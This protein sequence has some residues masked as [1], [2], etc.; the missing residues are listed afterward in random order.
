MS[1]YDNLTL[2][3]EKG[4][5][6]VTINRP[7]ALNILNRKTVH[8]LDLLSDEL[9]KD[10]SIKVVIIVGSGDKA[11]CAGG[12][13][14]EQRS[15]NV[16]EARSWAKM[17]QS[18]LNKIENLRQPVIATVNG[19]ALGGG[20]E[21]AMACDIRIA[22]D[23]AKFALPEV[24]LGIIPGFGGT[25]RLGRLIGRGRAKEL[26]F[27]GEMIDAMEAYR[28][29]LVNKVVAPEEL[30]NAAKVMAQ[31]IMSQAPF[32]LKVCKAA[33]MEGLDVDFETGQAYEAEVFALCFAT[34]DQKEGITAFLENFW[35]N[36]KPIL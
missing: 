17:G 25:Q 16:L 31:K 7:L 11:F 12:D 22:S 6:I 21:L 15:M 3:K 30:M 29:G 26:L 35:K 18:V 1:K 23:K 19:Y 24:S 2:F 5:G 34:N 13:I 32:A 8:E 14:S 10:D 36:A 27:T 4:I 28:I 33:V 9:S 20:C